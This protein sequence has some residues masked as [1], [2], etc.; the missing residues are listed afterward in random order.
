MPTKLRTPCLS[1]TSIAPPMSLTTSSERPSDCTSRRS[2]I[3][4]AARVQRARSEISSTTM[5]TDHVAGLRVVPRSGLRGSPRHVP[6]GC[7]GSPRGRARVRRDRCR[8]HARRSRAS[9]AR[10]R[11]RS[12]WSPAP[13]CTCASISSTRSRPTVPDPPRI[14]PAMPHMVCLPK[15]MN[16]V[17]KIQCSA[18]L[19]NI[20]SSRGLVPPTLPSA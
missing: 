3:A 1:A 4:S 9:A 14:R 10:R 11:A 16:T 2:A 19:R 20:V 7:A 12:R 17:F 18:N 5:R 13:R 6:G 15:C 8:R